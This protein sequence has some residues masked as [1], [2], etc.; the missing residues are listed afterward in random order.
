MSEVLSGKVEPPDS[1]AHDDHLDGSDD[2]LSI[3]G[4]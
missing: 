1:R 3:N 2:D 4:K